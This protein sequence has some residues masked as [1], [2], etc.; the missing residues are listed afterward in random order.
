M[1][2]ATPRISGD[3]DV[4]EYTNLLVDYN[5]VVKTFTEFEM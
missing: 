5:N 4:D 2:T 3:V 1:P